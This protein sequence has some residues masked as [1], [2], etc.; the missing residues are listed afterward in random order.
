MRTN[1]SG[2][3]SSEEQA[4]KVV[5]FGC[6]GIGGVVA[7]NLPSHH[8]LCIVT[9]N[10][11]ITEAIRRDGLYATLPSGVRRTQPRAYTS[12]DEVRALGPFDVA[13][14]AVPPNAATDA[15]TKAVSVLSPDGFVVSLQNGL[16]EERLAAI[17]G[18]DRVVG[19]VVSFGATMLGPGVV[20][21]TS[22]GHITFGQ[23]D[24]DVVG[25]ARTAYGMFASAFD[26]DVDDLLTSNLRGLRWSKLAI[27]CAISTLGTIG[28]DTVGALMRHRF[29]RRLALEIITETVDVAVKSGVQ[30]EKIA[31]TI[32]L[33]WLALDDDEKL[34][35]GSPSLV[36]KH[37][38][39]LL[40]GAKYRR[41]RS[42]MLAALERGREP[43]IDFL[44]GEVVARGAALRVPTPVNAA[45]VARVKAFA[46]KT[47]TPGLV[48]LQSLY[49][50]TRTKAS[51]DQRPSMSA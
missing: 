13:L 14:L 50:E 51:S 6:G 38:L 9:N 5:L 17:A 20:E 48:E 40:V 35:S 34:A 23:L 22:N 45:A 31:G 42:S 4:T 46:K 2:L 24:G 43:P 15:C 41:L 44:N 36:A 32:D 27:N 28:G 25:H 47:K 30:L 37:S 49:D 16:P 11:N 26:A 18:A 1:A 29:A 39:L 7:S 12:V 33:E 3:L 21:Q 19:G 8:E 10:A